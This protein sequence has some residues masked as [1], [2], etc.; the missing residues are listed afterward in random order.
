[1]HIA[2]T[3]L[4]VQPLHPRD[5]DGRLVM[6]EFQG[7][8]LTKWKLRVD[9]GRQVWEYNPDQSPEDQKMYDRYFLGLNIVRTVS[10]EG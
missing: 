6:A 2:W 5:L 3:F 7:T 1:M 4:P 9:R 10:I 8:D